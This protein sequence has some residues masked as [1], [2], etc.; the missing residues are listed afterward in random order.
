MC[1]HRRARLAWEY[2]IS[3]RGFVGFVRIEGEE[4]ALYEYDNVLA[5]LRRLDAKMSSRGGVLMG[6][7]LMSEAL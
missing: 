7:R 2:D 3:T 1:C 5:P 6:E 4:E